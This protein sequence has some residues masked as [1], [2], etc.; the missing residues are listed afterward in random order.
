MSSIHFKLGGA[1]L[2]AAAVA[3]ACS[4]SP[5][6]PSGPQFATAFTAG[7]ADTTEIEVCKHGT[8]AVFKVSI[9][10][11]P[12]STVTLAAG[13]CKVVA[14]SP[15]GGGPSHTATVT[16]DVTSGMVLDS[17]VAESIG[18]TDP[19]HR[20]RSAPITGTN[21]ITENYDGDQGWLLDFYNR[22]VTQGCTFTL[23]YW[24]NHTSVWPSGYSPNATFYT[25]GASWLTVLQTPPRGGNAYYI[26]AHQF[27]AAKLN[28][29]NGAS[30]PANVQTALNTAA[31][32]FTNPGGSSLSR[33][34][35]VALASL[36]DSYN[37]GNQGVVHCP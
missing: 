19:G 28:S 12:T 29:A 26:L 5:T 16:E 2:L 23:G 20:V 13:E 35:L 27:I 34:D 15:A 9:D 11:G 25:S 22:A 4:D 33:S 3:V 31:G 36:L 24:K 1:A 6:T 17:I 32:Y 18:V 8:A 10:G 21:T 14:K 37:N 30:V 7:A